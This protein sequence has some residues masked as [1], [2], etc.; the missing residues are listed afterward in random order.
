[1]VDGQPRMLD[2]R[3]A[4]RRGC[5]FSVLL[6]AFVAYFGVNFGGQYVKAWRIQ[7]AMRQE[8]AHAAGR[9]DQEIRRRLVLKMQDLGLPDEAATALRVVRSARPREIRIESSYDVVLELPFYSYVHTF[10]PRARQPL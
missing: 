7:G 3:G 6:L 5:L 1:V 4:G 2:E 9:S 10:R 8:A